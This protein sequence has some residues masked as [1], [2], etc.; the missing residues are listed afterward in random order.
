MREIHKMTLQNMQHHTG[1]RSGFSR[2]ELLKSAMA[3][4][5]GYAALG[6]IH[7]FAQGKSNR[8]RLAYAGTYNSPVDGGAGNGK[9]IYLFEMDSISGELTLVKLAAEARNPSWLALDPSGRYL[10]SVNEIADY[11]GRGGSVSAYAVDSATGD[12]RLLNRV[13]SEGAGPAHLSVDAS[14]KYV[15]VANYNG[16]SLAVLPILPSGELG[17]A[18][19]VEQDKGFVGS[20]RALNAPSGSFAISGHD[21]PHAH[22]IQ[23]DP[24]SRFVLHTDLGQDRIYVH[25]LDPATGRLNAVGNPPFVSLPSGDGPRHFVFHRNGKWLYSLQ[26]EA[27]N[28]V[29]FHFDPATGSLV[30]QQTISTLPAHFSGT[31]FTSE[32]LLSPDGRFLY[33]ANRLHDTIAVF[34]L[35]QDGR[36]TYVGEA[37]TEGDYPRHLSIDP[38]G[39]FLYACNQRS[40]DI[41]CFRIDRKTGMPIFTGQYTGIG[42]PTCIV[43]AS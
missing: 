22:M 21:K 18:A 5:A 25:S 33:A 2:R 9:G 41:T 16:G 24:G 8:K 17:S 14:G 38:S 11:E 30:P 40:D 20:T 3:L 34:S 4:A 23:S 26:E 13:S 6:P 35:N 10:Y 7:A 28:V 32:I 29:F 31:S 1:S 36:L 37:S 43:F 27:S 19:Y 15:F 39:A 12:L 42:S